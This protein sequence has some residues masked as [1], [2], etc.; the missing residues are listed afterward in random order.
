M[1][2][3]NNRVDGLITSN[4]A[5]F[6]MRGEIVSGPGDLLTLSL[7]KHCDKSLSVI[8]ML[9]RTSLLLNWT[10]GAVGIPSRRASIQLFVC[11]TT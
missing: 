5:C 2:F 9:L 10:A 4:F 3:L 7:S 11:S 6:K 8:R 1:D